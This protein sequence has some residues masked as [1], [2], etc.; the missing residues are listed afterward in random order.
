MSVLTISG[1]PTRQ[2]R[3]GALVEHLSRALLARGIETRGVTLRDVPPEDLIDGRFQSP[4]ARIVR[5]KVDAA[6]A[7][8]VA[9]PVYKA[10]FSGGLKAL[11]DLLPENALAGKTIL[12]IAT[13]GSSAHLLAIEYG[14]KPV[15]SALGARHILTG[16]YATD[17]DVVFAPDGTVAIVEDLIE[18]LDEAVEHIAAGFS[19]RSRTS[20]QRLGIAINE[21]GRGSEAESDLGIG[22][23]LSR[24]T[25]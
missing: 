14:L 4:A 9:T 11:L 13:G 6:Q 25:S 1:S 16:V 21:P 10:S 2:S 24:L 20:E 19:T 8:V 3:S 23:I 17:R 18:R 7:V 12:P 5:R 15:L 22:A